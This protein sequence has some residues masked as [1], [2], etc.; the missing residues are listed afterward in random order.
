MVAHLGPPAYL[1]RSPEASPVP[2]LIT[3]PRFTL[4]NPGEILPNGGPKFHGLPSRAVVQERQ[5]PC[6]GAR[7][8]VAHDDSPIRL[9]PEFAAHPEDVIFFSLT[10]M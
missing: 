6:D 2:R 3:S 9:K 5:H 4:L 10:P 8:S 7:P 1:A